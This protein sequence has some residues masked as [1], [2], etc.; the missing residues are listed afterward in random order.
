MRPR[1]S[2][3]RSAR[4]AFDIV[5]PMAPRAANKIDRGGCGT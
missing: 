3:G 1:L 5:A 2:Y 4:L